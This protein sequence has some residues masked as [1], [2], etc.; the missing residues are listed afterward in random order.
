M[1][2][3]GSEELYDIAMNSNKSIAERR[4]VMNEFEKRY[5]GNDLARYYVDR[6][7][8]EKMKGKDWRDDEIIGRARKIRNK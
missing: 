2:S 3:K 7:A 8:D 5:D 6:I 1:S 4:E